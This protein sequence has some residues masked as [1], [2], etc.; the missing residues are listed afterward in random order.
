[1]KG[2]AASMDA[3]LALRLCGWCS[4]TIARGSRPATYGICGGCY[5]RLARNATRAAWFDGERTL[6]PTGTLRRRGRTPDELLWE[7]QKNQGTWSCELW[8]HGDHGVEARILRNG[9]WVIGCQFDTKALA[10]Q[11]AEQERRDLGGT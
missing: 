8:D 1:M 7:V 10:V 6:P 11:W 2:S 4:A 3:P 9:H 5:E